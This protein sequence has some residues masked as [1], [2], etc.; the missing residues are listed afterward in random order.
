MAH[1]GSSSSTWIRACASGKGA[2]SAWKAY[3]HLGVQE[4][5][6]I[7]DA[8]D[9]LKQKPYVDGSRIGM[10]GHSYGGYITSYAMTHTDLFAA[11]IAGAPV[12]DWRDYDSIYTERF[13][14]VPQDNPR[15]TTPRRWSR[16]PGS[17]TASC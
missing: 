12:T 4:T 15:A 16:R 7:K 13:M 2:I 8:I 17:C 14:G 3:K 5:E 11:G 1:E 6:D 9:W 10:S